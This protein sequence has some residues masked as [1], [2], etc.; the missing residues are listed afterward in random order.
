MNRTLAFALG[1]MMLGGTAELQA[2]G[3]PSKQVRF[4]VP[5]AP[6]GSFDALARI[7][8]AALV[9]R[10]P[11]RVLVDNKPGG[12][13]NIAA[14]EV[15]KADP[16]GYTLLTWNDTLLINPTLFKDPP[17]DPKRDFA[18]VS[19]AMYSPN[20]LA[21]HPSTGFKTFDDFLKAARANPGKFNY[22][23]PG[24]GSPGHL[25][26]EILK[27]AA[28][29]DIVHVPYRGAGPAIID[30]VAGQIPLGMVAIPGAIGHIRN[31]AL[32]P[33][34]VTSSERVKALPDVPTIAQAGVPSYQINAFH[35]FLAPAGTPKDVIARLEK[36]INDV[37]KSP[38][39]NKKL[40][41][42][43]FDPIAGRAADFAALI[44]RDLP[45]WRDV[46]LKSGAKAE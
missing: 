36:D 33:L 23:S 10:W 17:F 35:G 31:G 37:I 44:D 26:A 18:P 24:N 13:G 45:V 2:Q 38:D 19:L 28:S 7:V 4:V 43:G 41:D 42:L 34:A 8:A 29:L 30:L 32:I 9:D 15:A 14:R 21:A 3:F 16:D 6:G 22:G 1:L 25:S 39:V 11:Q 20:V 40:V 27:R 5:A 46:V 12:A